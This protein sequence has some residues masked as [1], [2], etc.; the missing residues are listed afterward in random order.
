MP[1]ATESL[2]RVHYDWRCE[3]VE[4]AEQRQIRNLNDMIT[5]RDGSR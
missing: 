1:V 4:D 5:T 3:L 2:Y